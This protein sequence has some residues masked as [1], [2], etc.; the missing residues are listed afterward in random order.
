MTLRHFLTDLRKRHIFNDF[1]YNRISKEWGDGVSLDLISQKE[2]LSYILKGNAVVIDLRDTMAFEE[3]HI[4][5]AVSMPYDEFDEEAAMLKAYAVLI[6]CCERGAA[7]LQIGRRL[8]EKGYH[9]LSLVGGMEFW[10]GPT[11]SQ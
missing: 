1:E 5:G 7:S 4:P 6:L 9:V 2:V 8:S 3:R 11:I 10:K